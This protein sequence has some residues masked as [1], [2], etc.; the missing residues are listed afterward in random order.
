MR[1][2]Q[3]FRYASRGFTIIELIVVIA[4]ISVLG[5]IISANV[6]GFIAKARDARRKADLRQLEKALEMNYAK[7]NSYT[8]PETMCTDTS[9]GGFGGCGA[10]GGTGDWDA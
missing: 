7:Y 1:T 6:N 3:K 4:I 8:Q 10:A 2:K 5:S 9:Y